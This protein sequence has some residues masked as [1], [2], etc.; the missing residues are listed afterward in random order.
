[1]K[2]V[3]LILAVGLSGCAQVSNLWPAGADTN[4]A[5]LDATGAGQL[6]PQARPEAGAV[7]AP[8]PAA[9]TVE[10]F[11]TTTTAQREVAAQAPVASEVSL[12]TTVASLGSPSEPGFWLKTP[13]VSKEV[14][15][16]VVYP[17]TGKSAQVTLIPIDGPI[18][19][20]SRMSLPALRLIGAPLT[21]LPEV[22]VYSGAAT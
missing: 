21:G 9:R 16:R 22:Q 11:D 5:P 17:A 7:A 14:Q 15:G 18:T 13:L 12:G 4:G 6:R 2:Y 8:P 20:G 19:A 10:Q 1:M 3:F